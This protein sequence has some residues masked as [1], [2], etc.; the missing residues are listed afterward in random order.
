MNFLCILLKVTAIFLSW[1]NTEIRSHRLSYCLKWRSWRL[2]PLSSGTKIY[3]TCW[4]YN[5]HNHWFI[6]HCYFINIYAW[7]SIY[8]DLEKFWFL[9]C[10][11]LVW[12]I[13]YLFHIFRYLGYGVYTIHWTCSFPHR[14]TKELVMIKDH[15]FVAFMLIIFIRDQIK[16]SEWCTML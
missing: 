4:V 5:A 13:P 6:A 8:V 16:S 3:K 14:N 11:D 10:E 7:K 9:L 1:T 12:I 15:N 2:D